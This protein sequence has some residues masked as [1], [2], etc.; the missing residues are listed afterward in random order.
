MYFLAFRNIQRRRSQVAITVLITAITIF[1]FTALLGLTQVVR[2]GI[3]LS[4]ERLGADVI[5]VPTTSSITN[6]NLL[7]TAQPENVYMK[8]SIV[9]EV[10]KLHGVQSLTTQFF[11][12]T[13]ELDCCTPGE[14]AR[15]IGVDYSTDFIIAPHFS[16]AKSQGE[17]NGIVLGSS[18]TDQ[19]IGENYL[20]LGER[21]IISNKLNPTGTGLDYTI[22]LDINECRRIAKDSLYLDSEWTEKDPYE[23]ISS[24][25]IKLADGVS[26]EDFLQNVREA[27]LDVK[28]V[29]TNKTIDALSNQLSTLLKILLFFWISLLAITF[30]SL[31]GRFDALAR[32]RK[33][34]IG[35][36]RA[37]GLTKSKTFALI[38][39]EC[40][41]MALIGG[42][43]G[44]V[45][46]SLSIGGIIDSLREAFYLS[47]A[48][49]TLQNEII[50]CIAG[51]VVALLLGFFSALHSAMSSASLDPQ[52][53]MTEGEL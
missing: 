37:I 1:V 46:A 18:F 50:G 51:I 22:F 45:T 21:Y 14:K 38:I 36:L 44:S 26:P 53:A 28:V 47:S 24:V 17:S 32:E 12:Q 7:F 23:Y 25:M 49:W 42:V 4:R 8:K 10:Q 29:L 48:A 6:Q 5:L 35:L 3:S 9:D 16:E 43:I 33:K 19:N 20:V 41:T 39:I 30:I 11:A 52:V 31:F 40:C 13:L 2:D 15:I 27:G 34:E